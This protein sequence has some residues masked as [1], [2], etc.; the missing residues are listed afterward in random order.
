MVVMAVATV[1]SNNNS[2]Q[3]LLSTYYIPE[4]LLSSSQVPTNLIL[5]TTLSITVQFTKEEMEAMKFSNPPKI[6]LARIEL[7]SIQ[8]GCRICL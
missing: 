5:S 3:H 7:G 6:Q 8:V 4:N 1:T 2:S